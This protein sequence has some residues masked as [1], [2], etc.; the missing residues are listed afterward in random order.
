MSNSSEPIKDEIKATYVPTRKLRI[1]SLDKRPLE[2]LI[3]CAIT[4]GSH[5]LY[6]IG[7]YVIC[8]EVYEEAFKYE[9]EKGEFPIS[10]VC[11][12]ELPKYERMLELEKGSR[13]PLVKVE[14]H[15]D[16]KKIMYAMPTQEITRSRRT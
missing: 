7:G 10:Q 16:I 14:G 15:S 11:Y 8:T 5:K 12:S 1:L 2:D 3:W 4:S 13:I 6:W 9:V